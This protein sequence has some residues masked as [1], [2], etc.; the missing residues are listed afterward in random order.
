MPACVRAC[1][2]T[3]LQQPVQYAHHVVL[4]ST[5]N[6]LGGPREHRAQHTCSSL[7]DESGRKRHRNYRL[8]FTSMSVQTHGIYITEGDFGEGT[9]LPHHKQ[10]SRL[11]TVNNPPNDCS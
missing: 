2:R 3:Y 5:A 11:F 9:A 1:V 8:L 10:V 7:R 6:G 4:K